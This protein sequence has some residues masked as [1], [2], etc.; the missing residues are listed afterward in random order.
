MPTIGQGLSDLGAGIAERRRRNA[1][2]E[3]ALSTARLIGLN[4]PDP[5]I[6]AGMEKGDFDGEDGWKRAV[7]ISKNRAAQQ[8]MTSQKQTTA[9]AGFAALAATGGPES[10]PGLTI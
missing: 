2:R 7:A 6:Y 5:D 3:R 4:R 10:R 1:E 8:D 9:E